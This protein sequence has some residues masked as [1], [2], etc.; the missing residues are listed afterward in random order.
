MGSPSSCSRCAPSSPARPEGDGLGA[1]DR[2][3]LPGVALRYRSVQLD[4]GRVLMAELGSG[5]PLVLIH[6]LGGTFRYWLESA[7]AARA[8]TTAC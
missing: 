1:A 2:H 6:G 8:A 4:G 5:P 7:H 3:T